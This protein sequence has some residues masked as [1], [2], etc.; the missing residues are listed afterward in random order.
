ME[1]FN[2]K[3][4][5]PLR[6]F[7]GIDINYTIGKECTF[8]VPF[9]VQKIFDDFPWLGAVTKS[10]APTPSED[11]EDK[12]P[13]HCKLS[14]AKVPGRFL[15][16]YGHSCMCGH[17][18]TD[19]AV[20]FALDPLGRAFVSQEDYPIKQ[21]RAGPL[22]SK[23]LNLLK[24]H[25]RSIVGSLIYI[26][27]ACRPDLCFAV[28]KL[29]RHM[30]DPHDLHAIWLAR[31]LRYLTGTQHDRLRYTNSNN[32]FSP[33]SSTFNEV[34]NGNYPL[35][36]L[37]GWTDAN[38]ANAREAERKSISGMCFF[39]HGNCVLWKSK[40]QPLT[41]ASTHEAELIALSSCAD[42]GI[43]L[44]RVLDEVGIALDGPLPIMCDNQGTVFTVHNPN[45]NHRSK[46][47]DIRYFRARQHIQAGM[48]DVHHCPT[49][50]NIADFFTKSLAVPQF[51]KFRDA[52]MNS[53][54][55]LRQQWQAEGN[56][57]PETNYPTATV[58][59]SA[60]DETM[61]GWTSDSGVSEM[62][63]ET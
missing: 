44:R 2:V 60:V 29:S 3:D 41:A 47:L 49:Q 36:I 8:G 19:G 37:V 51:N 25:Y 14:E 34:A 50:Y 59:D 32:G 45:I 31:T 13:D 48:I 63:G 52:I 7:L 18:F 10:I 5:G 17:T 15:D 27:V 20:D 11:A 55:G 22:N 30:H 16:D 33:A 53:N 61:Q 43:W 39:L 58:S 62:K 6:S 9:K 46:H 21:K 4:W 35:E 54:R 23:T 26:M 38:H 24:Q 40:V 56:V 12:R 42:E 57:R 28:G 1:R